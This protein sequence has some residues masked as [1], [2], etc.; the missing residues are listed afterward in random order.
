MTLFFICSISTVSCGQNTNSPVKTTAHEKVEA[1][2]L[3]LRNSAF[4]MCLSKIYPDYDTSLNDGSAA[5]YFETSAYGIDVF[6]KL[7]ESILA[8]LTERKYKSKDNRNLGI[9]RCL[10]FY[11]SRELNAMIEK[12]DTDL[13]RAKLGK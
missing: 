13:D 4:C 2:K 3:K 8:Y 12:F 11:N 9:Q 1:E 6:E 10:D 5:G 7:D